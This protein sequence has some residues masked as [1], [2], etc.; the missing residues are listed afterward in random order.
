MKNSTFNQLWILFSGKTW[1]LACGLYSSLYC[2]TNVFVI[3]HPPLRH[4]DKGKGCQN[5]MLITSHILPVLLQS[6]ENKGLQNC[7]GR[8]PK[9]DWG[10][11]RRWT[12]LLEMDAEV[13]DL[14]L[15]CTD[16]EGVQGLLWPCL[17]CVSYVI[18]REQSEG[19]GSGKSVMLHSSLNPIKSRRGPNGGF[20]LWVFCAGWP[21]VG[22]GV[23]CSE[24]KLSAQTHSSSRSRSG[25]ST[26]N[27]LSQLLCHWR[28]FCLTILGHDIAYMHM[29]ALFDLLPLLPCA[30]WTNFPSLTPLFTV[31][32]LFSPAAFSLPLIS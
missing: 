9:K 5:E 25:L 27:K 23:A 26:S 12:S 20:I 22:C 21:A 2:S 1:L 4:P 7:S 11:N 29:C 16:S 30:A 13:N 6:V 15:I 3:I 31:F 18:D 28:T 14:L 10:C 19:S 24:V 32:F 17:T 8:R